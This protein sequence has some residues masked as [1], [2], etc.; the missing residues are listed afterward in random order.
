MKISSTLINAGGN[1]ARPTKYSMILTIPVSLRSAFGNQLDVLCKSVQAPAITNESYEIKVKGHPVKIPGR[2]IQ[3]NE[4]TITFY[5]DEKYNTR[6]LFQ[7]WILGLDN[8]SPVARSTKTAQI[9][10]SKDFYG[11]L[12]LIGRDY[13]ETTSKPI[14][15][16]FENLF[17]INIGEIEFSTTDKDSLS[18]VTITFA[19]SRFNTHSSFSNDVIEDLDNNLNSLGG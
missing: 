5:V 10:N 18:E 7:D 4:I 11:S 2:T 15:W 1:F 14:S 12:E 19:Y 9:I 16:N 17:P 8:R 13:H 3:T 6:K